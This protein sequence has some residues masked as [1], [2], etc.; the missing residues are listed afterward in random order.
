MPKKEEDY[1]KKNGLI[2][3]KNCYLIDFTKNI[4]AQINYLFTNKSKYDIVRKKGYKFALENF[5]FKKKLGKL[6]RLIN[7]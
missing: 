6:K 7:I 5:N 2:H 4:L 3:N 1:L